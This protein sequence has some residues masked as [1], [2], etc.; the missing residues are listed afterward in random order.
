MSEVQNVVPAR[1]LGTAVIGMA[2][3][4]LGI[5]AMLTPLFTGLSVVFIVGVIVLAGGLVRLVWALQSSRSDHKELK[6]LVS[7]LTVLCGLVLTFNPSVGSAVLTILLA[8]YFVFDGVIEIIAALRRRP[9]RGWR[10]LLAGGS[11]SLLLG[12]VAWQQYPLSGA[13]A[14]GL[15]LG[16]KLFFIGLVMFTVG[17]RARAAA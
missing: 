7:A 5:L 1:S 11:V 17:S 6:V 13:W 9:D 12:I 4:I 3:M 15:L 2:T 10:W 8:I 14:I 16:M